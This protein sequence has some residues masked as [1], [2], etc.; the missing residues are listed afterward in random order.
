M[1]LTFNRIQGLH[2]PVWR[3]DGIIDDFLR[4]S[5]LHDIKNSNQSN[6]NL[7]KNGNKLS[8]DARS[9][10]GL[11]IFKKP[12]CQEIARRLL[13]SEM[14]G[15]LSELI[16]ESDSSFKQFFLA[17]TTCFKPLILNRFCKPGSS[18]YRSQLNGWGANLYE[19]N[20]RFKP[21]YVADM[22]AK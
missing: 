6:F 10:V 18:D 13:D 3:I 22:Y 16:I 9:T 5:L 20:N 12:A 8:I 1:A 2:T 7:A 21:L 15:L 11:E 19:L 4:G 17:S 14:L